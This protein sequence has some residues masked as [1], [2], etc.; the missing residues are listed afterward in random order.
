MDHTTPVEIWKIRKNDREKQRDVLAKEE[1]LEI[2]IANEEDGITYQK[3]IA[4]TMRTPGNDSDLAL[5]FL[6]TEGIIQGRSVVQKIYPTPVRHKEAKENIIVIELQKGHKVDLKKL[7]R[8]FYTSSSC[9]VC[10]KASIEA[11]EVQS[12]IEFPPAQPIVDS[13]VLYKLPSLLLN[14]Q[15]VFD[16]TGGLHAA[17]LFDLSGQ[18]LSVQ[19]DIGRHNAL[20]KLIGHALRKD[21]LPLFEYMVLV[22]GRI[23]FELVQKSAIA[24]IP[25]L[26]AVGAPS[27][28][29]VS[30]AE[31][32]GITLIGFLKAEHYNIYTHP[33]RIRMLERAGVWSE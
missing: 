16:R 25:I 23:G 27:S 11:V 8:H 15:P 21:W 24:G 3:S 2:R 12:N 17:A 1:P 29:A 31:Q 9:G 33:E 30:L 10:G 28:L 26:A 6:L 20:D 4:V 18:L 32:M 19:E 5:G 13:A 7:E 22:S 14:S